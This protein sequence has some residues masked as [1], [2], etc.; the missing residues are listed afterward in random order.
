MQT[1]SATASLPDGLSVTA[2]GLFKL[3]S[4]ENA[5]GTA[6]ADGSATDAG[7]LGVGAAVAVNLADVTNSATIGVGAAVVAQRR[8]ARGVMTVN[9]ADATNTFDTETTSGAAAGTIGVAGSVSVAILTINTTAAISSTAAVDA[10]GGAI[11]LTATSTSASTNKAQPKIDGVT[12][13]TVGVGASVSLTVLNDT[14]TAS[15]G[16]DVTLVNAGSL[17]ASATTTDAA[18][19]FAKN[20]AAGG[21]ALTADVAIMLSNVTTSATIASGAT[22]LTVSGAITLSATQTASASSDAEGSAKGDSV[23]VGAALGLTIA[24]HLVTATTLR[25]L[26]AGGAVTLL[27]RTAPR[28]ARRTRSRRLRARRTRTRTTP[29]TRTQQ[30]NSQLGYANEHG[31]LERE[32]RLGRVDD[33]EGDDVGQ[34]RLGGRGCGRDLGEHADRVRDGDCCPTASRSPPAACSPF[35]RRRTPTARRRR[36]APRPTPARSASAL[37]WP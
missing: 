27:A 2:G 28:P 5:D 22:T 19:G 30:S 32:V 6:K 14:T 18:T 17:S 1:A 33:A 34:R 21:V 37:P 25:N 35:R 31:E 29:A 7:T 23:G 12:A 26:S 20:G 15:V 24:N 13:K 16:Q 36:T 9:G 3:S 10:G 8:D 11:S 4:S